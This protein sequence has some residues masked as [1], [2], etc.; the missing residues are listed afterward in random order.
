VVPESSLPPIYALAVVDTEVVILLP[1]G[2]YCIVALS[3]VKSKI[4]VLRGEYVI[5][6][7]S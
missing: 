7:S 1:L 3:S 6:S 5:V 4:G 2:L